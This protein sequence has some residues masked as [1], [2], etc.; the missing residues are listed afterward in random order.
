MTM[1]IAGVS[2]ATQAGDHVAASGAAAYSTAA[3][4]IVGIEDTPAGQAADEASAKSTKAR[5]RPGL[6]DEA[7]VRGAS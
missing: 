1:T 4:V 5:Q 3:R 7:Q 6:P 2:D